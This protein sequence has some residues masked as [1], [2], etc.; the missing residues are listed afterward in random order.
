MEREYDLAVS[1]PQTST[2]L[3]IEPT[4]VWPFREAKIVPKVGPELEGS[5]IDER[6][7]RRSPLVAP[8]PVRTDSNACVE[9]AN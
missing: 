8:R 1:Q 6:A 7:L 4:A 9:S 5:L 2:Y 3:K